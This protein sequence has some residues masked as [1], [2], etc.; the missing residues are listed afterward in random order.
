MAASFDLNNDGVVVIIGSGAGGGTLGNELAQKGV[1]V[2][3]LEAGA[4]HEYEDFINDEWG[5]FAQL[6]WTDKRTTSGDW[7]VAKDFPNLPA[8]IVKSVGGSTTHW[9]GA[10]LRFQEHEFKGLSTYG[11][12]EGANLLDWPIT[13]AEMEPYYAKAEAKM[14]VT[15]TNDWPRLPG[16]NNFKVLKAGADKL[17]YKECHT[18]NM[19]INSVDRDDRMSCQ[20]TGFCFQGCKWG[21][22][23]S[24][25]YTEI[26]KGEATGHLEVRP[27]AM[28][29]KINHDASGKVTGVV[30]ADKDGK[31]QEQKA[32]IV[33]VAGNSIESPRL[34]LNSASGKFPDGLANSSGQVGKNYM[35]HTTGSVYA[36]FDKPVHMYRGTTM[37]G[38]IRDEARHDPSRG[39]VGGYEFETLSLG[40]PFMAAFLDPGAW[41]RSFTTALDHYDHMAGL[42]IV[43]EDMPRAENRITLHVDE[44]DA[45]GMPIADV[46][47][48]DHPNDTAMRNHAY[49][50]ATALYD[51]VGATRT[52]PTPP[53]PSTHNLG[54]NRMSE[55]AEDGVVNKHGQAHDI[56]NLFVSDGSQFTTGA[57]ENPTLTIVSLAIRQADYIAAQMS[58]KTI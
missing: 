43:G 12:L 39:F 26:P 24:T 53:Y 23:W 42:W 25:L 32:R 10:S 48:D 6:A 38:I 13:L 46:H 58:A 17:G 21:A 55:K 35:R 51:A 4:R 40:L 47:F 37:A 15:G 1:D 22:K 36:I 44:K 2:V 56:K 31:L 49:K 7:R 9:A 54:T 3:I 27:N 34:L 20:Q 19:A 16:N 57:A 50:Q 30:Y 41:G 18:G 33:A 14:G 11:K 52:F 5:S 29:I 28:A 45:H 8:W